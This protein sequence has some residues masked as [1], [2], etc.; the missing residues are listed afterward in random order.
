LRGRKIA[1][2][3]VRNQPIMAV[4]MQED[5]CDFEINID[6]EEEEEGIIYTQD[7]PQEACAEAPEL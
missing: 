6:M 4:P 5:F 3:Q 2:A 1:E 7:L